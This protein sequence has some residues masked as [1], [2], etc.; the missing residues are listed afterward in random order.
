MPSVTIDLTRLDY[1]VGMWRGSW[2]HP[3]NL[4]FFGL[5]MVFIAVVQKR[6]GHMSWPLEILVSAIAGFVIAFG[7]FLFG[8]VVMVLG[9]ALFARADRGLLGEHTFRI[10]DQGL[11]E[12]TKVNESLIKWG[13][14]RSL[15]RTRR[16]IHIRVTTAMFH[17]IPRRHFPDA[18]A[19]DEFW[20][21]LQPLVAKKVS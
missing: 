21:A 13:G 12:S 2:R 19:D 11:V 10:T 7:C 8:V 1:M 14:V 16:Y 9:M 4:T 18:A 6:S 5:V 15:K 17:T 20:N 3:V